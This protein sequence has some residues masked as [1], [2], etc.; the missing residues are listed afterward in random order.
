MSSFKKF[1]ES[2]KT[3][4]QKSLLKAVKSELSNYRHLNPEYKQMLDYLPDYI[5]LGGKWARP[6]LVRLAYQAMDGNKSGNLILASGAIELFHRFILSHDDIIDR[7]LVRHGKPNL[8]A[9]FSQEQVK[10][11]FKHPI[12]LYDMGMAMISGDLM[13]SLVYEII[14]QSDFDSTITQN[15]MHGLHQCLMETAAGWRLETILKQKSIA[16]VN[17]QQIEEAM[18]LVS[19]YYSVV[20]PLRFGQLLSGLKFGHWQDWFE[21]YGVEIGLAFQI[22]DDILGIFGD[23]QKTGKPSAGDL[24]EAKKTHLLLHAFQNSNSEDK[25]Y[26]ERYIGTKLTVP[27]IAKIQIIIQKS[28]ALKAARLKARH[29]ALKGVAAIPKKNLPAYDRLRQLGE[30]LA[31]REI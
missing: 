20:W 31:N 3:V 9:I 4:T 5:G 6:T 2:E 16:E 18:L 19:G 27:Q 22:Q 1:L 21:G 30:Y 28:G 8:E 24:R 25:A 10:S 7:D 11:N 14:L 15:I 12:K 23:P 26:L 17:Y 29:H 13:H